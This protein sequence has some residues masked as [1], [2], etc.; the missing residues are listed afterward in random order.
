MKKFLKGLVITMLV[1]GTI[2]AIGFILDATIPAVHDFFVSVI[3]WFKKLFNI[4]EE[5]VE[6]TSEIVEAIKD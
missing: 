3:D 1:L 4:T 2:I 6:D 5:V